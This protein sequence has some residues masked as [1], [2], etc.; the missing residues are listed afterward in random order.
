VLLAFTAN[1]PR[2]KYVSAAVVIG[3]LV[4]FGGLFTARDTPLVEGLVERNN[5]TSRIFNISFTEG[6]GSTRVIGFRIAWEAF[7]DRPLLGWGR[8]N[9][10]IPYQQFQREGEIPLGANILDRA[11]NKPLDLLATTGLLGFMTY[12]AMWG[13]L[14]Y[15]ALRRV[16]SEPDDRYFH[17]FVAG[18]LTTLFV[19]NLFLFDMGTTLMLFGLIAAWVAAAE[20]TT[21]PVK[22]PERTS[23]TAYPHAR[24]ALRWIVPGVVGV[25]VFAGVYGINYR[26]F[27]AAQ[28]FTKTGSDVEEVVGNL[29]HFA[30]L[31]TFGMER[32]INVMT[33][34]CGISSCGAATTEG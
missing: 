31:A 3:G 4:I 8:E 25:I 21:T 24:N 2:V 27:R 1:S 11:H 32:L 12:L 13:W 23:V 6:S 16:R 10:E 7:T 14:G 28:L 33:D 30:P 22:R 20:R 15:L 5:L 18:A 29:D 19:H 9:F 26:T 34:R 17:I